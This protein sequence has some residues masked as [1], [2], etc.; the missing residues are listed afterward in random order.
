MRLASLQ[1]DSNICCES[2]ALVGGG[3]SRGKLF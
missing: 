2:R 1:S 3:I